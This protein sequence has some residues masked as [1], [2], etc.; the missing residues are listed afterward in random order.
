MQIYTICRYN[1]EF[2]C[3]YKVYFSFKKYF[4]Y[5]YFSLCL[6]WYTFVLLNYLE[7][8]HAIN[9]QLYNTI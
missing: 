7:T 9:D 2:L 5:S 1:I 6:V 3:K 8:S 4:K